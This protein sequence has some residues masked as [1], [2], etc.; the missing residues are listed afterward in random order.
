MSN[1]VRHVEQLDQDAQPDFLVTLDGGREV[2]IECKN[3]SPIRRAN[4]DI[5]VEVQKTRSSRDD[6]AGRFYRRDQFDLVAASLWPVAG[7]WEFRFK[8]TEAL[9]AHPRFPDRVAPIQIVDDDTWS[10]T[11]ADA[12]R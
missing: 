4:G 3:V 1:G 6:P 7:R 5:K 12:L 11:V 10:E 2:T 8:A 9:D